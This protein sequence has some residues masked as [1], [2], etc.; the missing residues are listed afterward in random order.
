MDYA[1]DNRLLIMILSAGAEF[2]FN[3]GFTNEFVL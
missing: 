1:P 2:C 3:N